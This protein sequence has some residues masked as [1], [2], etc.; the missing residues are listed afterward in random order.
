MC[1]TLESPDLS[2]PSAVTNRERGQSSHSIRGLWAALGAAQVPSLHWLSLPCSPL[3]VGWT[4]SEG[5]RE[6]ATRGYQ[7][8]VLRAVAQHCDESE[9]SGTQDNCISFLWLP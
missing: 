9:L 2:K 4:V 1:G 8:T 7:F 6:G 5:G 3:S